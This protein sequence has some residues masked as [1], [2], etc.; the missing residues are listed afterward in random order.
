MFIIDKL[1]IT[2]F[3]LL[4]VIRPDKK[5]KEAEVWVKGLVHHLATRQWTDVPPTLY[6]KGMY[7]RLAAMYL[8][9][10][11]TS[12]N[13]NRKYLNVSYNNVRTALR[14]REGV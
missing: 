10:M 9:G 1:V 11:S 12:F 2:F 4:Y 5:H 6:R 13:V 3:L 14:I 8:I 7:R